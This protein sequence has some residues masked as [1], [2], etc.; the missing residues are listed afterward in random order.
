MANVPIRIDQG[1]TLMTVDTGATL[2]INGTLNGGGSINVPDG[3]ITAAKLATDAVETAKIKDLN[4]TTGK[5]AL[6]SVD[7]GQIAANAVTTAKI[8][9]ANVTTGKIATGAVTTTELGAAAVTKAK[10]KMFIS[11]NITGD[12]A[13]QVTAHGLGVDPTTANI[14]FSVISTAAAGD[15]AFTSLSTDATNVTVTAT[16]TIIYRIMAWAP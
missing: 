8:L 15:F 10:A 1:G 11:G 9:N 14:F 6:L 3:S 4:V 7:T 13:P 16:N 2:T 12:G 5:L